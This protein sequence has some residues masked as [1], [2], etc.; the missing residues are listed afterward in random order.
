MLFQVVQISP[1]GSPDEEKPTN[2]TSAKIKFV[3][4]LSDASLL[5]S[6]NKDVISSYV[7]DELSD[8]KTIVLLDRTDQ[9]GVS[10]AAE[11]MK[12]TEKFSAFVVHSQNGTDDFDVSTLVFNSPADK[13]TGYPITSDCY[14]VGLSVNLVGT[15]KGNEVKVA[16]PF[17][18]CQINSQEQVTAFAS[19]TFSKL[20][21]VGQNFFV[22]GT[23][24]N[25]L[26]AGLQST[27]TSVDSKY[28]VTEV[29]AGPDYTIF[30]LF[31]TRYWGYNGVEE[32]SVA[33]DVTAYA[34]DFAWK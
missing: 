16:V 19:E 23:V 2:G 22:L 6:S 15:F 29:K 5:S 24:K 25:E 21:A 33:G 7:E 26:F 3:S 9:A 30:L 27:I 1:V 32:T 8:G 12:T 34:V 4:T 31:A 13:I 17:H 14:T 28:T 10:Y 18:Y 11:I 20:Y